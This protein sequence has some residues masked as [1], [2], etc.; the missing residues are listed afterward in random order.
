MLHLR[1]GLAQCVVRK[2]RTATAQVRLECQRRGLASKQHVGLSRRV[3][4]GVVVD[5]V[6]AFED[7]YGAVADTKFLLDPQHLLMST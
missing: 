7:N 4:D 6:P 5:A 1:R 2:A 3:G